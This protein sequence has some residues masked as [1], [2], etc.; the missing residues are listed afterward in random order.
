[1]TKDGKILFCGGNMDNTFRVIVLDQPNNRQHY[2]LQ[3]HKGKVTC[4]SL[5]E[6]DRYLVTGSEDTTMHLWELN[7]LKKNPR[8]T[9]LNHIIHVLYGHNDPVTCVVVSEDLNS[10]ISGS[11]GLCIIHTLSKGEYVRHIRLNDEKIYQITLDPM[12]GHFLLYSETSGLSLYTINGRLLLNKD[13]NERLHSIFLSHDG[14]YIITGGNKNRLV[15]RSLHQ[16]EIVHKK[17]I[18]SIYSMATF[19]DKFMAIGLEKEFSFI[20]RIKGTEDNSSEE[21]VKDL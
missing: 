14:N 6:T 17:H 3:A 10:V 7:D 2:P 13:T 16:L 1:M 15:V 9:V 8:Q 21:V 11:L 20:F 18:G 5:S 12:S 19:G 4:L